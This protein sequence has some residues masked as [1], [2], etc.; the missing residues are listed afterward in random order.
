MNKYTA[1]DVKITFGGVEVIGYVLDD[2]IYAT[3]ER[4]WYKD[5]KGKP[6]TVLAT[7]EDYTEVEIP[8]N[9]LEY[10]KHIKSMKPTV[11]SPFK[12]TVDWD[13]VYGVN[14]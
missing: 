3:R 12:C 6:F 10:E 2:P 7:C 1:E 5:V 8:F 4:L 14:K 13:K 9:E 11:K